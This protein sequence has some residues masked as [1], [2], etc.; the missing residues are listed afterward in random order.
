[1]E[2]DSDYYFVVFVVFVASCY[3]AFCLYLYLDLYLCLY[4]YLDL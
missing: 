1:M 3:F 4:L 2:K